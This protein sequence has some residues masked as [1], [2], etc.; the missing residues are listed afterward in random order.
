MGGIREKLLKRNAD[1]IAEAEALQE[2]LVRKEA[3]RLEARVQETLAGLRTI[4]S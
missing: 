2:A 1:R 3:L 4:V